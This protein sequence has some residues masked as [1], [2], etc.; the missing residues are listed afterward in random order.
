MFFTHLV[1]SVQAIYQL[2]KTQN[3][4]YKPL[5]FVQTFPSMEGWQLGLGDGND[6]SIDS[7]A[8]DSLLS[9]GSLEPLSC[10]REWM[11]RLVWKDRWLVDLASNDKLAMQQSHYHSV[12]CQ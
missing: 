7:D 8:I 2:R 6:W 9:A 3:S 5:D 12:S 11:N 4:W 1:N 10:F